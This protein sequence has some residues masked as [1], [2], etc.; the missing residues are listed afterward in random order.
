MQ[1]PPPPPR[2]HTASRACWAH[3]SQPRTHGS[4]SNAGSAPGGN[5]VSLLT[6]HTHSPLA[7]A[8]PALSQLTYSGDQQT[9]E[10]L[11]REITAAGAD[12]VYGTTGTASGLSIDTA[13]VGGPSRGTLTLD[14]LKDY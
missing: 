1:L 11:D 2:G 14:S 9:F 10:T 3:S 4:A 7:A 12:A 6:R 13:L 5:S 8:T